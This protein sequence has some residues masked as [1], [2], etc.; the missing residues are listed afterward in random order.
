MTIIKKCFVCNTDK[1]ISEYYAHKKMPDGHLNKCKDCT[2]QH[3]R[4]NRNKKIEYYRNF[5]RERAK[6]DYRKKQN[7]AYAS[8]EKGIISQSAAKKRYIENNPIKR[9]VHVMVGN[10]IRDGRI[11]KMPCEVCGLASKVHAHHDDY[12]Y[13][14][15][16]RWLCP[17]HHS[18]WHQHNK[19]MFNGKTM[20]NTG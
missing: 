20:D 16:V 8:S 1:P 19:T 17:K 9:A 3:V 6:L 7:K 15:D 14:F 12:A 13:P 5:D 18:E 2:K 11:L 4:E 10:A